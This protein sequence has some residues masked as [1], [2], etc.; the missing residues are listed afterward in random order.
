MA[1]FP[2]YYTP[3]DRQ[4][5]GGMQ[6][7]PAYAKIEEGILPIKEIGATVPEQDPSGRFK[8]VVEHVKALIRGGVGK[9]QLVGLKTRGIS[10]ALHFGKEVREAL[11]EVTVANQ[12]QIVGIELPTHINNVSGFDQ[13]NKR[14][15]EELRHKHMDEVKNAIRLAADIG[16]GGDVDVVSWE[17]TRPVVGADWNEKFHDKK[18]D[19]DK[20][21]FEAHPGEEDTVSLELVDP[22]EGNIAALREQWLEIDPETFELTPQ[23]PKEWNW[24]HFRKWEQEEG[25]KK[26]PE[27]WKELQKLAKDIAE[28][29]EAET[30]ALEDDFKTMHGFAKAQFFKRQADV[31]NT[32]IA[33]NNRTK[34]VYARE[35]DDFKKKIPELKKLDLPSFEDVAEEKAK[36]NLE[37]WREAVKQLP[38][39]KRIAIENDLTLFAHTLE[40]IKAQR[41]NREENFKRLKSFKSLQ[42]EA[43]RRSVESYAELGIAAHDETHTNPN[44]RRDVAVGPELGWPSFYGGHPREWAELI[45]K[46]RERM[47]EKLVA[48]RNFSRSEAKIEAKKHIR[49]T[50]DT[51]HMGMWLKHFR[52]DLPWDERVEKFNKWYLEQVKFLAKKHEKEEIIG[53]LQLV[54]SDSGEHGH[55]PP[56]QGIFPL[57]EA[58]KIFRDHGFAGPIVSEGHEEEQFGEGRIFIKAWEK[59]GGVVP[60]GFTGG[61]PQRFQ[62]VNQGYFWRGYGPKQMFGSYTPPFGEYRPWSEIP[63][64]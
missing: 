64:E 40:G 41:S 19:K 30:K 45:L 11:R 62:D 12:A 54:D 42:I 51:S 56:G 46:S 6:E 25:W 2:N 53:S 49:G 47:V 21:L 10:P 14:L 15:S 5:Y 33:D 50:F 22:Q 23:K 52:P 24:K 35:L 7:A 32:Q 16:E 8:N 59:F 44:I 48:D 3:M 63:F 36:A 27:L 38:E 58:A 9:L 61:P 1:E 31:A 37:K 60:V 55:L 39:Q 43:L 13:Q 34:Q 28:G 29:D 20:W 57:R 17:F 4:M 18:E 26:N